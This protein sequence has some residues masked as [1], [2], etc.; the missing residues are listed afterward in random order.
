VLAAR[1]RAV[2]VIDE[3]VIPA[4]GADNAVNRLAKLL[5]AGVGRM[6]AARLG[7]AQCHLDMFLWDRAD[8]NGL[9]LALNDSRRHAACSHTRRPS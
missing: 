3:D 7:S 1:R 8:L 4:R 2:R 6:L 5:V 9:K